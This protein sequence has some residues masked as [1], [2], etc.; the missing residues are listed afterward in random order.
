[1]FDVD[2]S[3]DNTFGG[4]DGWTPLALGNPSAVALAPSGKIEVLAHQG[5]ARFNGDGTVDTP[6]ASNGIATSDF[7]VESDDSLVMSVS[8]QGK[9]AVLTSG[10][11]FWDVLVYDATG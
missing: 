8:P 1:R 3:L 6:F 2:G 4:G 5:L 11:G 10:G 9:T 7:I